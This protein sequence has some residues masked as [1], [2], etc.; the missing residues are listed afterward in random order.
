MI[1]ANGGLINFSRYWPIPEVNI[2]D[3]DYFK[4]LSSNP[5]LETF[6]SAPVQNR[7]NGSWN[8]Y[9]ARR[10]NDPD[11]KFMGLLLGALSLQYIEN[12]FGSTSLGLDTSISLIRED[13]TLMARFPHNEQIGQQASRG[14]QRALEAGGKLREVRERDGARVLRSARMLPN[15]P[16]FITV[17]ETEHSALQSWRGMAA[18]LS[19]MSLISTL[20]IMAA[21]FLVSRWWKKQ[22][23]LTQAAEAA[24]AAKSTFLAMM[25]H[26]IRTPMN[27]VLGLATTLLETKMDAEQRGFVSSIHDAGDNLLEI[28]NDILD[29]SKLESGQLSLETIAFS[30]EVLVH[31]ALSIMRPRASA[32]GL[33]IR[34]VV[35]PGLPP[36]LMGDAGRIRQILLNLVS[37]AVKFTT[38]G[39]VLVSARCIDI[40]GSRATI[41]WKVSDTGMGI[42]PDKIGSL[43]VN[44]AQAD[45]TISRRFGGSGL[46]LAICKRLIEQMGGEIKVTSSPEAGS[47]FTVTLTFVVA[48][49]AVTPD[50]DD[51]TAYARLKERIALSGRPLRVLIVDDNPT[52]RLVAAKL[53]KEFDIQTN[54]ACDGIEAVTAARRFDYDVILMDVRMP[55]M[56]GLQ[57]TREIRTRGER[58]LTV[59][60]VAFTANAFPEDIAAC[61]E[62][63]M[64]DF[65]VKPARK[66]ALVEAI[67]RVLPQRV[68]S[69]EVVAEASSPPLAP[70]HGT[71]ARLAG[72]SDRKLGAAG[73]SSQ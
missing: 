4:A 36:A 11:G 51:Q 26:E 14:P 24:N 72:P 60:I 20:V 58:P 66:K 35:E 68:P 46:G 17:A 18:L 37:N 47:T 70:V 45:N 5:D 55:E 48:D 33:G 7:G 65:V 50:Q 30:A 40:D 1:D 3:R 64:D 52:N 59:P 10:L 22:E 53:L 62:A 13:G 23:H 34:I 71:D 38:A 19:A 56:D 31:N 9:V 73:S 8:V 41:E 21:A 67:L 42:A 44:F 61:R 49:Q 29:F 54:T 57:A 2:S 39:E 69:T 15:Y 28:L 12:F 32:K 25:S 43:F 16:A 63:G 6:L 27:A